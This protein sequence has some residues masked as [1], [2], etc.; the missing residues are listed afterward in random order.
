MCNQSADIPNHARVIVQ[1]INCSYDIKRACA[2]GY[3]RHPHLYAAPI[4]TASS[5]FRGGASMVAEAAA[6]CIALHRLPAVGSALLPTPLC[7]S[8][9]LCNTGAI[10]GSEDTE[11]QSGWAKPFVAQSGAWGSTHLVKMNLNTAEANIYSY[12]VDRISGG[13]C[14]SRSTAHL[15]GDA[16][17]GAGRCCQPAEPYPCGTYCDA[18]RPQL[19]SLSVPSV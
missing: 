7:H 4:L 17:R 3:N 15:G 10:A 14:Q 9:K 13:Y 2:P 19:G 18:T 5:P 16:P 11:L 1:C 12:Y 8:H 6:C